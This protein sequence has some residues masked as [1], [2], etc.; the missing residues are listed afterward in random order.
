MNWIYFAFFFIGS[1][2][3]AESIGT[4]T[5]LHTNDLHSH[6]EGSGPD[7]YFTPQIDDGDPI[8][9]HYA[10]LA[11]RIKEIRKTQEKK[12]HPVL[13]LDS[14]DFFAGSLF[15]V[16]APSV[17][18]K[19]VPELEFFKSAG[20]DAFTLGNHE[21]DA[22]EEG[23]QIIFEKAQRLGLLKN[24]V[25]SN[26][27][28]RK[29]NPNF[30]KAMREIPQFKIQ[31]LNLPGRKIKVA[32][33]GI[34]GVDA[35]KV[36][37][38]NR[39]TLSVE[40]FNDNDSS[41]NFKQ[42]FSKTQ[43]LVNQ[44]RLEKKADVVIVLYHGGH[45]EDEKLAKNVNGIDV[46]VAGHTHQLYPQPKFMNDTL[47]V[48][49]G[50]YGKNLGQLDLDLQVK[51][52]KIYPFL[53]QYKIHVIDDKVPTDTV[54][55]KQIESYKK[56]I[57][58]SYSKT[59][60][61]GTPITTIKKELLR[62]RTPNDPFGKLVASALLEE[63]NKKANPPVDIYMTSM[64]L[65]REDFILVKNQPTVYQFSDIFRMLP[66]GFNKTSTIQAGAPIVSF[67]MESA[68]FIKLMDFMESY[69]F[70]SPNFIGVYS[71]EVNYRIRDWGI[72]F[73]NRLTD[74][75][76]KGKPSDQWPKLVHVAANEYVASF[77]PLIKNLSQ[78]MVKL[79]YRNKEGQVID[80]PFIE[81]VP[82]EPVL[83]SNYLKAQGNLP[84][85]NF[86]R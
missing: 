2:S 55:L 83:F 19:V 33:L 45:F 81:P 37:S 3:S 13:A 48:Q 78:G 41:E 5:I 61:Y 35:A 30:E 20:Y 59:Y 47:I 80:K 4:L 63:I 29:A 6:F 58:E 64:S 16:L 72:P 27:Y 42:L 49:A 17:K 54:V 73:F 22:G 44:V 23:L 85:E 53:A 38:T 24:L 40:G 66:I 46:I 77:L 76:F 56:L 52:A 86:R 71:N 82:P 15:Q 14:G 57:P 36:S 74:V 50:S 18:N 28:F 75:T 1:L 51:V 84:L 8:K 62:T 79:Q 11:F 9:G 7:F 12:G 60:E 43:T 65:I 68:E 67:Y 69:R 39:P 26:S 21:F 10:R 32:I 70:I 25:L 34:M 31:E